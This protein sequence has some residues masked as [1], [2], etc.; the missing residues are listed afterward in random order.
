MLEDA[1]VSVIR[2]S[3]SP[4]AVTAVER[5]PLDL[6]VIFGDGMEALGL[7]KQVREGSK[8]A[9]MPVLLVGNGA[10]RIAGDEEAREK[11]ADAY[12]PDAGDEQSVIDRIVTLLGIGATASIPPEPA[13]EC[14][15]GETADA[16]VETS[17]ME[18][19]GTSEGTGSFE[20]DD[21]KDIPAD[22]ISEALQVAKELSRNLPPLPEDVPETSSRGDTPDLIRMVSDAERTVADLFDKE[23]PDS[24][25]VSEGLDTLEVEAYL[26]RPMEVEEYLVVGETETSSEAAEEREG[27]TGSSEE[28]AERGEN[29]DSPSEGDRSAEASAE[30]PVGT[31]QVEEREEP[32]ETEDG[33]SLARTRIWELIAG[34][35]ARRD[36][37][38]LVISSRGV[39]RRMTAEV[40]ELTMAT[41]SAREDRLIELLH[42]E[43]RLSDRQYEQA[44][45]TIGASGRR[46]GAVL[47]EK[48]LIASRELFPLVRHHYEALIFDSFSW[49]EG[50]WSFERKKQKASER[51]LLDLPAPTIVVEGMR[52][53]ARFEDIVTIMPPGSRPKR[54]EDGICALDETGLSARELEILDWCDGARRTDDIAR[55]FD[56]PD[57]ELCAILAGLAAL[58]WVT[59]GEGAGAGARGS[60]VQ[61]PNYRLDRMNDNDLRVERSRIADKH[62]QVLEGSYFMILEVPPEAS[63]YEIRKSYRRLRGLFAPERFAVEELADLRS[64]AEVIRIVLEE[65]YEVLR[66]SSLRE[67]YRA[68]QAVD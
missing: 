9:V 14:Y 13:E 3:T 52:S 42:R 41:S 4:E 11:G 32:P 33:G 31:P 55:R 58:G 28:E 46:A 40:G 62:F 30:P 8:G 18:D 21:T 6:C 34:I 59:S 56:L 23:E 7:L 36:S 29:L 38:L 20:T 61:Q 37:G 17:A 15:E 67:E 39:E 51:I 47:V 54:L 43:G 10:G 49:T 60:D 24:S 1:G 27:A 45:M 44:A 35:I 16:S 50:A 12:E 19:P 68:A 25:E 5:E 65:A 48:G 57:G 66:D 2:E 63:G 22:P 53:R 64:Q 26:D